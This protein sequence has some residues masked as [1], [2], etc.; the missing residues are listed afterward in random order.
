M[1]WT[2][3][4]NISDVT[5]KFYLYL[6]KKPSCIFLKSNVPSLKVH[7]TVFGCKFTIKFVGVIMLFKCLQNKQ[8]LKFFLVFIINK[9]SYFLITR[10]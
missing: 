9:E 2:I 8:K 10:L 1:L 5:F 6:F 7:L 3:L 4:K